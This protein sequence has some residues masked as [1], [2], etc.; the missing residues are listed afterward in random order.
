M[1]V[2]L[3]CHIQEQLER[4]AWIKQGSLERDGYQSGYEEG[5]FHSLEISPR[6]AVNILDCLTELCHG[7]TWKMAECSC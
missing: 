3:M 6:I 4:N 1:K 2:L 5:K 7:I